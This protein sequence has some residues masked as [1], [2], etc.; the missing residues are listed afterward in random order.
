MFKQKTGSYFLAMLLALTANVATA[1]FNESYNSASVQDSSV[2]FSATDTN[3]NSANYGQTFVLDLSLGV[4]GLGYVNFLNGTDGTN[5]TLT[6]DLSQYSA[7]VPFEAD[8]TQL[9]WSV[10]AAESIYGG[11]SQSAPNLATWG[12]LSTETGSASSFTTSVANLNTATGNSGNLS[13]YIANVNNALDPSGN[14][15][16]NVGSFSSGVASFNSL[17]ALQHT[18][19]INADGSNGVSSVNFWFVTNTDTY[20]S[21]SLKASNAVTELGSF[22]LSANTLSY[23][24][25]STSA[26]PLP[27]ATWLF[28]SGLFGLMRV[29]RRSPAGGN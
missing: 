23:S 8:N 29:K 10:V 16:A 18:G 22:S 26:V 2:I 25:A 17:G 15:V 20:T 3:S 7:F 6:W 19:S 24:S 5:G 14:G 27:A 13:Q 21:P 1:D 4:A 9:S 28:L 11:L 12:L